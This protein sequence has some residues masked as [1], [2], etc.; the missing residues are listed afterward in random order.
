MSNQAQEQ[1]D[2]NKGK[3]SKK[4]KKDLEEEVKEKNKEIEER[5]TKIAELEESIENVKGKVEEL[6]KQPPANQG[7]GQGQDEI[8]ESLKELNKTVEKL[9]SKIDE[10]KEKVLNEARAAVVA[11][12]N[13]Q[14]MAKKIGHQTGINAAV[15]Q[16]QCERA[17]NGEISY[18]EV[19]NMLDN[20]WNIVRGFFTGSRAFDDVISTITGNGKPEGSDNVDDMLGGD[21]R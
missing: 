1:K 18:G 10:D 21:Y 16:K 11:I 2:K 19:L 17:A 15:L 14:D 6:N 3:E 4:R 5:D 9:S 12:A 8:E 13:D 7:Q 20:A